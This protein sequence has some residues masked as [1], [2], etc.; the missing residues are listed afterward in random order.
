MWTS[1][2]SCWRDVTY[3]VVS[4]CCK[5]QGKRVHFISPSSKNVLQGFQGES[6][7]SIDLSSKLRIAVGWAMQLN[8]QS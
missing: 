2:F 8:T 4:G 5:G 6:E 1:D 3:Q 7:A